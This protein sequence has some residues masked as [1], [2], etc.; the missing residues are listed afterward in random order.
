MYLDK[1]HATLSVGEGFWLWVPGATSYT[2]T[3]PANLT[4]TEISLSQGWNLIGTPYYYPVAWDNVQVK[5]GAET[6]SLPEAVTRGW[7]RTYAYYWQGGAYHTLSS[8][9]SFEPLKGYWFYAK[10]SGCTLIFPPK[11]D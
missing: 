6:V 11:A 2:L 3:G 10:V 1:N 8:G 4:S 7:V 5:K 9:G